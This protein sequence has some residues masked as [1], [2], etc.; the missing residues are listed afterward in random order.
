VAIV[1]HYGDDAMIE[2]AACA[3][4]L[5]EDGDR[6]D[7]NIWHRILNAIERLQAQKPAEGGALRDLRSNGNGLGDRQ[8][9]SVLRG[10]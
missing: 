10:G 9:G 6:A 5:T 3:D 8:R 1:K 2:T 4:Q 7:A